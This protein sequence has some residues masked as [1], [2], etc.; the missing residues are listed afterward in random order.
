MPRTGRPP[1]PIEQKRRQGTYRKDRDP[2]H[3]NLAAV[4]AIPVEL[5]DLST[6]E[7]MDRVLDAGVAW[8]AA[9]DSPK[10]SLLREAIEDYERLRGSGASAKDIREAR[11]EV[12]RLLGELGFDPTARA[13]LGLAEVKAASKMEELDARR[14][15]RA[16][17]QGV[18]AEVV[19]PG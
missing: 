17:A 12:S 10:V 13:R 7:A 5:H 16:R 8:I 14:A 2:S 15:A 9:T 11:T 4:P 3:G 18:A 1:K 6:A 19:D